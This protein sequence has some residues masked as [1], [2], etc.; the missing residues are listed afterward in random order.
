M[1]GASMRH[2]RSTLCVA[3]LVVAPVVA[4]A[5]DAVSYTVVKRE[6]GTQTVK[7]KID[8]SPFARMFFRL[9]KPGP[10]FVDEPGFAIGNVQSQPAGCQASTF[11]GNA[12]GLNCQVSGTQ[13][14]VTFTVSPPQDAD[15]TSKL[16]LDNPNGGA[17]Q[18]F[19][20][21]PK[22]VGGVQ[23]VQFT[24]DPVVWDQP[25]APFDLKGFKGKPTK[26]LAIAKFKP[27]RKVDKLA[28]WADCEP[29]GTADKN[30]PVLAERGTQLEIAEA[31]FR[32][33]ADDDTS[34]DGAQVIGAGTNGIRF[35]GTA[36]HKKGSDRIL[37]HRVTA[38]QPLPNQVG[39]FELAIE[40][41]VLGPSTLE[42]GTSTH[43]VYVV[44]RQP[45]LEGGPYELRPYATLVDLGTSAAAGAAS[46][47]QVVDGVWTLIKT[48]ALH[49]RDL[50]PATGATSEG[51]L[52]KYWIDGWTL[53]QFVTDEELA[54]NKCSAGDAAV[55]QIL[56]GP[57][58]VGTCGSWAYFLDAMLRLQGV[59]GGT[60]PPVDSLAGF[61]SIV[62][63]TAPYFLVRPVN[64][65]K[66]TQQSEDPSRPFANI[67]ATKPFGA[68]GELQIGFPGDPVDGIGQGKQVSPKS[69]FFDHQIFALGGQLYDP[70]YGLGPYPDIV[71][72]A[73]DA[74][75][76]VGQLKTQAKG[77]TVK[78]GVCKR[79]GDKRCL[80]EAAGLPVQ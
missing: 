16:V 12:A 14:T 5:A 73:V 24:A 55:L 13:L 70:A 8:A 28:Q 58:S 69:V 20:P 66:S 39:P 9:G 61:R 22:P 15:S 43:K 54:P 21:G 52:L 30:W 26:P 64:F 1:L 45:L 35:E 80:F 49:R 6:G 68:I 72:W 67:Y 27:C 32:I 46:D 10:T 33:D 37:V 4:Q 50:D 29:D 53:E 78:V 76:G 19:V 3:A 75:A 51:T 42:M 62:P 77:V 63:L 38:T 60:T 17:R 44:H 71:S 59:E 25:G 48:L 47:Q 7:L 57:G 18:I 36:E 65:S 31:V 40:W 2:F 34:F 79:G 74:L 23:S 41:K 56:S 11:S